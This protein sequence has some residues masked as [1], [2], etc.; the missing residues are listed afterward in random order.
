MMVTT[1][2]KDVIKINLHRPNEISTQEQIPTK[3]AIEAFAAVYCNTMYVTGVGANNDEIWKYKQIS[4]WMKCA[5]LVQG[6]RRHSAAFIDEVLYIC[7]GFVDSNKNVL[8]SVEAYNAVTDKC[9]TV[10][11]LVHC[12]QSSGNCVPFKSSLYIF[13][14][15]R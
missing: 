4:G 3:M 8:D 12:V 5:S 14:G 1:I 13:G 2:T 6:R 11:K 9:T 7:G 15:Y 10:G